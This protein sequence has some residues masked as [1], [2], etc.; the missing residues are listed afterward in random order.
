M[1]TFDPPF[2]DSRS[3]LRSSRSWAP[4]PWPRT[5][6]RPLP[7]RGSRAAGRSS[8]T[9]DN[10]VLKSKSGGWSISPAPTRGREVPGDGDPAGG[11]DLPLEVMTDARR[12]VVVDDGTTSA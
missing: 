8:E 5:S 3:A 9:K 10:V 6:R 7:R 4:R 1:D 11:F 12:L 2:D